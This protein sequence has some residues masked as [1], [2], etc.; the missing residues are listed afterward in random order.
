MGCRLR[1]SRNTSRLDTR[2]TDTLEKEGVLAFGG[3]MTGRPVISRMIR[4]HIPGRENTQQQ[5]HWVTRQI[6]DF[7]RPN[8]GRHPETG[9]I[10]E[11]NIK[12][13]TFI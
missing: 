5:P 12:W 8:A 7:F 11:I 4:V 1:D 10:K 3:V 9:T 2:G 13:L 6:F